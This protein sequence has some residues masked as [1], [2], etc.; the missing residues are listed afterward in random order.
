MFRVSVFE[1]EGGGNFWEGEYSGKE[2]CEGDF[3]LYRMFGG[4]H[5]AR[6]WNRVRVHTVLLLYREITLSSCSPSHGIISLT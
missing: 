1:G 4:K 6:K 5:E 3:P 2:G